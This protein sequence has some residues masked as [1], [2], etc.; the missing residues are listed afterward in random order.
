MGS[1]Y[2]PEGLEIDLATKSVFLPAPVGLAQ[3]P[4]R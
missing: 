3:S 4:P 2:G 1:I